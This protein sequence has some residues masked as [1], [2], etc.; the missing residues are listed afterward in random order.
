MIG[1]LSHLTFLATALLPGCASVGTF[2]TEPVFVGERLFAR[3]DGTLRY[4][5]WT[6]DG[7]AT[8]CGSSGTWQRL[9][10]FTIKTKVVESTLGSELP[11]K[12]LPSVETW[13]MRFGDWHR[14]SS[15]PFKRTR[16]AASTPSFNRSLERAPST[17][18]PG[19]AGSAWCCAAQLQFR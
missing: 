3:S 19:F 18:S 8:T 14:T 9:G 1:V 6:D 7:G 2:E 16:P 17:A 13:R 15:G 12:D 5:S 4:E 11:C 10:A